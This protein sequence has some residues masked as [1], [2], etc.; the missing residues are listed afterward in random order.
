MG[1]N[2]IESS[3]RQ[4]IWLQGLSTQLIGM[5]CNQRTVYTMKFE[6]LHLETARIELINQELQLPKIGKNDIV[7]ERARGSN[8]KV[9]LT[10]AGTDPTVASVLPR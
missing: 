8:L 10:Y 4:S 5:L 1:P 6:T 7:V 9:G 3:A 2:E